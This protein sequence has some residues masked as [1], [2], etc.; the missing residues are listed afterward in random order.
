MKSASSENWFFD[1]NSK[2]WDVLL[3]LVLTAVVLIGLMTF[4]D[5]GLT[6]DEEV[7]RA[8][9]DRVLD[10]YKS[11]FKDKSALTFGNLYLYGG[12]FEAFLQFFVKLLKTPAYETRHLLTFGCLPLAAYF[13]AKL[14]RLLFNSRVGFFAAIIL[15]MIPQF[16]SHS[17]VNS[18]DVPFAAF[19]IM[20]LYFITKGFI[21]KTIAIKDII[22]A[23]VAIGLVL[24]IRIGGILYFGYATLAAVLFQFYHI[25]TN[26]TNR[27]KSTA[28]TSFYLFTIVVVAWVVMLVFW[29]WAQLSPIKHPWMALSEAAKFKWIGLVQFNGNLHWSTELP[30]SYVPIWALKTTPD[31][32]VVAF[33]FG[34]FFILRAYVR[35]FWRKADLMSAPLLMS[36]FGPVAMVIVLKSVLYDGIRHFLFLFPSIAIVSAVGINKALSIEKLKKSSF[37]VVFACIFLTMSDMYQLHPYQ[38]VYFN[39]LFSKGQAREGLRFETDYWGT[40]YKEGLEWLS[41]YALSKSGSSTQ[42]VKVSNCSNNF[43]TGY[44]IDSRPELA[45]L[46]EPTSWGSDSDFML[47]TSRHNCPRTVE[48][49]LIHIV[50][51]RGVPL[52]YIFE[53]M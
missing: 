24:A 31:L 36:I 7:Q 38:H 14:G 28:L 33:C 23:G 45:A 39:R 35:N 3:R 51:K 21:S 5:Y 16:Y 9:G 20:S 34:F 15:I 2:N 52:V 30:K 47:A 8:Y 11:F 19:G 40:S 17:F 25:R 18:K 42:R 1:S 6:W 29:P 50:S 41:T 44:F 49:K 43:L 27:F 4:T 13:T 26:A 10:W 46:F 48:G 22:F 12:F 37:V 53:R 32:V